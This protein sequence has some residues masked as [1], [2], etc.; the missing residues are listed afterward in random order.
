MIA[1]R[2]VLF[3]SIFLSYPKQYLFTHVIIMNLNSFKVKD[4]TT[5]T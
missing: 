3:I 1:T 2:I 5:Q 4:K